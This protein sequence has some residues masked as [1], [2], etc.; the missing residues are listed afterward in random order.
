MSHAELDGCETLDDGDP[1]ELGQDYDGLRRL[2]P[3][4]RVMGGCYGTDARH[5]EAIFRTLSTAP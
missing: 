4:L 2:L 3:N 1:D 5:I